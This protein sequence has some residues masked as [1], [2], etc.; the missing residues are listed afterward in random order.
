MSKYYSPSYSQHFMSLKICPLSSNGNGQC[1]KDYFYWEFDIK[2]STFS[3]VY[4]VLLI[5]DF[6]HV[7]P[8]IYIL[9]EEVHKIATEKTIPHLYSQTQIQ[10]C[11]YYPSYK[12]FSSSIPLCTT[13]IPWTYLWLSYYE[14]WLYSGEWK[15]GG[16]HPES[17]TRA[18]SVSP[19]RK[20]SGNK[21]TKKK[22]STK[23]LVDQV[24]ERRKKAYLKSMI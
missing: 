17:T 18:N 2:P 22:K 9:N 23:S 6:Q 19:L 15:G 13:I 7:A 4:R 3:R 24:Y 20:V 11:L 1:Y 21:K 8:K 14:E 12:E 16:I 5:W 10:L